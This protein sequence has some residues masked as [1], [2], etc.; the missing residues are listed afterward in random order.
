MSDPASGDPAVR[1]AV[2]VG[3]VPEQSARVVKEAARYARLLGAPL[4]IVHVDTTRFVT[5]EDPDGFVHSAPIDIN[6]APGEA[7]L[8]QVRTEAS[9]VLD[10][11]GVDWSVKQLVGDPALAIKHLADDIDAKLLVIGTRKRGLGDS[12]R[13]FFTGS[14]AARLAHRQRRPI[15]VV[16][17]GEIVPDDEDPFR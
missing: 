8:T 4:L 17:I 16:P 6:V 15:L 7:E 12:I 10:G 5:Y 11:H 2:I 1:G 14:V 13:E 3:V 9:A